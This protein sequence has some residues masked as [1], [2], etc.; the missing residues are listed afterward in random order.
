GEVEDYSVKI[1]NPNYAALTQTTGTGLPN[2][3]SSLNINTNRADDAVTLSKNINTNDFLQVSNGTFNAGNYT[4]GINGDLI[5]NVSN[6]FNAQTSTVIISG[7]DKDTVRGDYPITLNKLKI[8]KQYTT[9]KVYCKT[10]ITVKDT[11]A[12]ETNNIFF[13]DSS[14]TITLNS[15]SN[16]TPGAGSFSQN[17]MIEFSNIN[18]SLYN[19]YNITKLF[20]S[21]PANGKRSFTFP[22]GTDGQYHP[23]D[24]AFTA[25]SASTPTVSIG[26]RNFKHPA[27]LTDKALNIFWSFSSSGFNGTVTIDSLKMRYYDSNISGELQRYIPGRHKT[28]G[29]WEINLGN[30]P[31]A[32]VPGADSLIITI[33]NDNSGINGDYTAGEPLIYFPGR[34]FYSINT[35]EWNNKF[36]WSND[37]DAKHTGP[38]ASYFPGMLFEDDT[39]NIDGHIITFKDSINIS[40]DS[41]RIGGTNPVGGQGQLIF[42]ATPLAKSLTVRQMFLD[43]DG[44]VT[45]LTPGGRA[46]TLKIK[47]SL[48]NQTSAPMVLRNDLSNSTTLKFIGIGHSYIT[49]T[50]EWGQPG[51]LVLAK[52]GGLSD[53]LSILSE[54]YYDAVDN[55]QSFKFNFWS[56]IFL[57]EIDKVFTL[58]TANETN[59]MGTNSG[60]DSRDGSII[61]QAG[62]TTN[63]N[64]SINIDGGDLII[65]DEANEHLLYKTGTSLS[66][67]SGELRVAGGLSRALSNSIMDFTL[68]NGEV[69]VNT[70]GNTEQIGFDLSNAGSSFSMTNGRIIIANAAGT[71]PMQFDYR[72][73]AQGGIGMEG[74]I[75]QCG[76]TT[77]TPDGT[78]IKI[79]GNLPVYSLHFANDPSRTATTQITEEVF[80]IKGNWCNDF[81]HLFNLSGNTVYLGGNLSNYGTF[82]A[83]PTVATS[84]PWQIVLNGTNGQHLLSN[85]DVLELYN[86][87]IDKPGGQVFLSD[88]GN[89]NLLIRNTLEFSTDNLA[90]ITAPVEE[91]KYVEISPIDGVS[92]PQILRNG[93]GHIHG[94][95]Y[96]YIGS[97]IQNVFFPI[98]ADSIDFFRPATFSTLGNDNTPGLLGI[99]NHNFNHP[100]ILDAGVDT[101]TNVQ[102]YWNIF[103]KDDSF[104]LAA[105]RNYS[106]KLQFLNPGDIRNSVSPLFFE[107]RMYT[108]P[109]PDPP[110]ACDGSGS[111]VEIN[112]PAR[113]DST[114][115]SLN[116]TDFGDFVIGFPSGVTFYSYNNGNWNNVN[117]WSWDGYTGPQNVP[118]RIP[119][120]QYDIVRVGN[121]KTVTV[122]DGFIP[123]IRSVFVEK[124]NGIP[125][126]LQINGNLN[127]I[128]GSSF[129]L[130]DSCTLGIQHLNGIAPETDPTRGAIQTSIR[131][132]GVSRYL[133][134][135]SYGSQNTGY[136]MPDSIKAI[137]VDNPSTPTNSVFIS[138]SAGGPGL[139]ILDS[140]Y[141][142]QGELQ[143]G[144]RTISLYGTMLIDSIN[145]NNNVNYAR[146]GPL[147][148]I[149]TFAGSNNKYIVLKNRIGVSF[150]NLNILGGNIFAI[151]SNSVANDTSNVKIKNTLNFTGPGL[152]TLEQGARPVNLVIESS[153]TNRI[154]GA[155]SDRFIRTSPNSGYLKRRVATGNTYSFP[156]GS[157]DINGT[158]N[159]YA[160]ASFE[161]GASGSAGWIAVRTSKGEQISGAHKMISSNPNAIFLRRYW[162]IDSVTTTINGKW[163][164]TYNDADLVAPGDEIEFT[165]IGRWRPV[166][167]QTPGI[168]ANPFTTLTINTGTN[169]FSTDANFSYDGFIGDWLMGN[170]YAFRRIFFSKQSGNWNDP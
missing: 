160:P 149:F 120:E 156:V 65:G 88:T 59:E 69:K 73:N 82:S 77:L 132:F 170:D 154:T 34:V 52:E 165:K 38:A 5:N 18:D 107:Q 162:T 30:N 37:P 123:R 126:Y 1:V 99:I 119:N 71:T 109:C 13:I 164:F 31:L 51:N 111:W 137:I 14:K 106:L 86:L 61:S 124:Y 87:R 96:R 153:L 91:D 63:M 93:K 32:K 75:L 56:G 90:Y 67:S 133:F 11:F 100:D 147:E 28:P 118:T 128:G 60:I 29:G 53:T 112:T 144:N 68:T 48:T 150:H 80:N 3:F 35:G 57:N 70:E 92:N 148:G 81:N 110:D 16:L 141:I 42:G 7:F 58:S 44:L 89:S 47:G 157:L 142:R 27:R 41:I 78:L 121:G 23:A 76:D 125:G 95:L 116:N 138:H 55:A 66:I 45:G 12:L 54:K 136:G 94:R 97:G 135:S 46:D 146:F 122:P 10:N 155:A 98:G 161:A 21:V 166:K 8:N 114:S 115:S 140:I 102:S 36:N 24:L 113:T 158:T 64:T 159:L 163:N 108:P 79:G 103:P 127:Y 105:G 104:R 33:K 131:N 143:S 50:G 22:L 20:G 17:R 130:A 19:T 4:I 139:R 39:V 15:G 101:S 117:T 129:S 168:W 167:E 74:G 83:V 26:L 145:F 84:S 40:L 62:L 151:D 2:Y 169:T 25:G 152:F 43:E 49:G 6:G 9:E 85:D 72:V 134:N